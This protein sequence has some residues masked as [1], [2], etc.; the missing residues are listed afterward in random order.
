MLEPSIAILSRSRQNT[1][2]EFGIFETLR[3]PIRLRPGT[4]YRIW[5]VYFFAAVCVLVFSGRL[6]ALRSLGAQR[7]WKV[8]EQSLWALFFDL[9]FGVWIDHASH[10]LRCRRRSWGRLSLYRN[11]PA[12]VFH[13]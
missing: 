9:V 11:S 2:Y 6:S 10:T 7:A 5:S 4:V 3:G 1:V 13:K 8:C 12:G